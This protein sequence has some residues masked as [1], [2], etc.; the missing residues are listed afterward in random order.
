MDDKGKW[1]RAGPAGSKAEP[2]RGPCTSHARAGLRERAVAVRA[3][4]ARLDVVPLIPLVVLGPGMG[5]ESIPRHPRSPRF[6]NVQAFAAL[7]SP[8]VEWE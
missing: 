2:R 4:A 8:R 3:Q 1:G 7:M 6:L 5:P